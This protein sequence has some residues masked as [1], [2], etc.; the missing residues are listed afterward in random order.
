MGLAGDH[1]L[2]NAALAVAMVQAWEQHRLSSSS[3]TGVQGDAE[4]KVDGLNDSQQQQ[5]L[6]RAA[7]RLGQLQQ[8]VLPDVYCQG[9]RDARWPGRSQVSCT[10]QHMM[11]VIWLMCQ[12]AEAHARS[13]GFHS[14]FTMF[15]HT[16]SEG[17]QHADAS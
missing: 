10:L 17:L 16:Q 9:L 2:L 6:A 12:L 4:A 8:G 11:L 1:Q 7:A 14:V 3:S 15:P 13:R 5:G